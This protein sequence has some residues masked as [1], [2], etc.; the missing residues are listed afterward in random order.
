MIKQL[1]HVCIFTRDLKATEDFY[2]EAFGC[3]KAFEFMR[4]NRLFGFYLK[5][6]NHTFV[7]VF[8]GDA[9]GSG[10]INHLALEVEDIDAVI[11]RV[12]AKGFAIEEKKLGC[13]RSWQVWLT[14]PNGVRIELQQYTQESRQF[15]GGTCI[16]NW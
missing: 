15:V 3:E 11:Q 2:R 9:S 16:A 13:D 1:A 12:K 4:D 5:M 14:D 6:G 8:E 7:E 10:G